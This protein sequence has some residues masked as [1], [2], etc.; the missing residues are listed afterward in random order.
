MDRVLTRTKRVVPPRRQLA[1]TCALEHFTS[2]LGSLVLRFPEMLDGAHSE[3]ARLWRWHSA[4]EN[5][6]KSV[7]FDVFQAVGGTWFERVSTMFLTTLSFWFLVAMNQVRMMRA[8]GI[9]FSARE[10]FSLLRFLF[11]SRWTLLR[12]I[13]PYFDYYR[14]SF[15][16]DLEESAPLLQR[17]REG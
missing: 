15:R 9:L 17:W 1:V 8:D 13:G 11:G 2:L 10:W 14:P 3:M 6:H 12:L 16:P 7:A 4:E 5:E